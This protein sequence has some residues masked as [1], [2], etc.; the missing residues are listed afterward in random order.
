MA[1]LEIGPRLPEYIYTR[2]STAE[3]PSLWVSV[4]TVSLSDRLHIRHTP[5]I[6][7]FLSF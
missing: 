4:W 6:F 1:G 7:F 2:C 5:A 3:L